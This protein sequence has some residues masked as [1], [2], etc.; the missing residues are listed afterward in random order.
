M[1]GCTFCMDCVRACPSDNIGMLPVSPGSD[2]VR[3]PVRSSIGRLSNRWDL[4]ALVALLVFG[5]FAN[6]LGM[7]GPVLDQQTVW[8]QQLGHTTLLWIASSTFIATAVLAP[9]LLLPLTA[10]LARWC[11]GAVASFKTITIRGT[12]ALIPIGFAMWLVHMLFHFFTSWATAWPA[13]Q[14]VMQDLGTRLLGEPAWAMSCCGPTPIWL[15]PL[16]IILLDLGLI[17][18]IYVLYRLAREYASG[19]W[20]EI[21]FIIPW[22]ILAFGLYAAGVWIVLQP[23]QMRGTLLPG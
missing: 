5:G 13:A 16:E 15:I 7:V 19:V 21:R 1:H 3:D 8:Q 20:A 11:S 12:L 6:A 2:L 23:M 18:S 22:A 9:L 4:C 10:M 14:R 17:V